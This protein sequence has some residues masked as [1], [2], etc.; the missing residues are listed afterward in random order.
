MNRVQRV[1]YSSSYCYIDPARVVAVLPVFARTDLGELELYGT[2]IV[3]EGR[4]HIELEGV[5]VNDVM[6][7]LGWGLTVGYYDHV[8]RMPDTMGEVVLVDDP[9]GPLGR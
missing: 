6:C 7:D 8:D 5:S 2:K 3:C 9:D 4:E 1:K